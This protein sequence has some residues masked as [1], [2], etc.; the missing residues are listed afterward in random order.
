VLEGILRFTIEAKIMLQDAIILFEEDRFASPVI[1]GTLSLEH[2]G[3]AF[4]LIPLADNEVRRNDPSTKSLAEQLRSHDHERRLR[5]G[6]MTFQAKAPKTG[7]DLATLQSGTP[8]LN[9][10]LQRQNELFQLLHR[11]EPANLHAHRATAQYPELESAGNS[12]RSSSEVTK[13]VA[14]NTLLQGVTTCVAHNF[15]G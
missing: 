8:E 12:W 5:M 2:I 15:Y 13:R 14:A 9:E 10:A 1:L 3:Q 6:L 4:W 7:V 11:R